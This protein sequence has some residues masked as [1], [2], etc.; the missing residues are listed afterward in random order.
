MIDLAATLEAFLEPP[1]PGVVIELDRDDAAALAAEFRAARKVVAAARGCPDLLGPGH[2]D[3]EL[4]DAT[5]VH[6]IR[7]LAA[8]DQA[9]DQ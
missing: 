6:L 1:T 8:Y 9:V 3:A 5:R 7:M 2:V 4:V